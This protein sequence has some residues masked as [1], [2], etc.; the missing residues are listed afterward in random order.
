M[1]KFEL[2]EGATLIDPVPTAP[3]GT[4]ELPEGASV[5]PSE[6]I[7]PPK[8]PTPEQPE[9]PTF[10]ER[11]GEQV[12]GR[13]ENVERGTE[14]Y[15]EGEINYPQYAL[16]GLGNSFGALAD[17]IGES[18]FTL[19]STMLP[20]EAEDFLEEQLVAGGT[21]LMDT[22]TAQAALS[23]YRTL[24]PKQ[25]DLLQNSLET[26][27]GVI[28][29]AQW[30]KGLVNKA[31]TQDKAKISNI[32]LDNSTGAKQ[33]R[34]IES[35]L[36][37]SQQFTINSEDKILNTVLSLGV[38]GSSKPG[39]IVGRLNQEIKKLGDQIDKSLRRSKTTVPKQSIIKNIDERLNQF[40]TDNP[41]YEASNLSN[42][43]ARAREAFE[44]ALKNYDGTPRG[45]LELRREFDNN[46]NRVFAKDVHAGDSASREIALQMRN[47]LND[48]TQS[49]APDA[50]IRAMMRRQ[51]HALLAREN[52]SLHIAKQT[53]S[54]MVQKAVNFAERH[55][56]IVASAAQGTGMFSG[57]PEGV[58]VTAA[59]GLGAYGMTRAPALRAMGTTASQVPVGRGLL[60][61]AINEFQNQTEE[62]PAQ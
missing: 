16:Y 24:S 50:D 1:S 2:P 61:G 48:I 10:V 3:A 56:F 19:I 60:Y 59:A 15:A 25:K 23:F 27:L 46:I 21:K 26:T 57:I 12:Q 9:Q 6:P 42:Q 4:K 14:L 62:P 20:Q 38:T 11:L 36:D 37:K 49:V 53:E 7:V 18:A 13:I 17:V 34:A 39:E 45:L 40:V 30:G 55:P 47:V 33:K 32:V 43:V 41:I 54:N 44:A 58:G 22:E 35:G 8:E 51:H 52:T 29:G 31:L 5:I 28:P